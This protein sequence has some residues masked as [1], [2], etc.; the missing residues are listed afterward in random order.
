[1]MACAEMLPL[2][3][4]SARWIAGESAPAIF[5]QKDCNWEMIMYRN[6]GMVLEA[7]AMDF[8]KA[9]LK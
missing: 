3:G 7:A 9:R 6:A 8:L 2:I 4:L 5:C 1:M